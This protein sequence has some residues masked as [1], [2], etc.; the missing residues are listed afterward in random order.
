MLFCRWFWLPVLVFVKWLVGL[1][2]ICNKH[3]AI[4]DLC[5]RFFLKKLDVCDFNQYHVQSMNTQENITQAVSKQIN[6]IKPGKLFT[7]QDIPTYSSNSEAVVK[8]ISRNGNKLGLIKI[9]KGLF[10]K[11]EIGRF[12]PM[13]PKSNELIKYF[14]SDKNKKVGYVTGPYLYYRWGLTTQVPAEINIATSTNK[15]EKAELSGL[16]ISTAPSR[17][18][19]TKDNIPILQFLDVLKNIEKVSDVETDTVVKK[20]SERLREYSSTEIEEMQN[21]AIKAYPERTKAILGFI[22]DFKFNFRSEKLH[23]SLNPTSKFFFSYTIHQ[24]DTQKYWHLKTNK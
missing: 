14:T 10:Y 24:K 23:S 21:I 7:Y 17:Y 19:V 20:L 1:R 12:G 9:K 18:K 5:V 11:P 16:R 4:I 2:N 6:H 15:R 3:I 13:T 8:A 22:L